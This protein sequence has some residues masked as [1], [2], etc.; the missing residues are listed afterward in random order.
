MRVSRVTPFLVDPG[1]GKNLCFVKVETDGG[2]HGWGECYT[3]ADRDSAHRRARRGD[4]PLPGRPRRPFDIKHF[5]HGPITTSRQARL[6]GFLLRDQR[7]R[8]GAVGHRGQGVRRSRSTTCSAGRCRDHIRVYANGWGGRRARPRRSTRRGA[9]ETVARGFTALKFD[10]FP[11]PWRAHIDR[12]AEDAG[13]RAACAR[14]ARRSGR[15][16]DRWSRCTGGWPRCTRSGSRRRDGA[17]RPFWYEEPV[18]A[19][20]LDG[21]G[22]VPARDRAPDRHRRGAVHQARVPR[23]L[24]AARGRHPQ[25]R[26]LQLRRHPGADARSP[27]WPSPTLVAVS[28]HNYNSTTVGLAGDAPRLPPRC[29]TS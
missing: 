10:P 7:P 25:P 27:R 3:Q 9:R 22:R 16:R 18:S 28:P 4:R 15:R 2:L 8:A 5:M 24:R 6:D 17:L 21:P 26:R 19:A 1:S 13:G 12:A 29:P 11:G 14:C 20:N 23:G